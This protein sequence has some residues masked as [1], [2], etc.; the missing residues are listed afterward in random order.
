[1]NKDIKEIISMAYARNDTEAFTFI[2]IMGRK[3]G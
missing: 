1:M 3:V 2:G